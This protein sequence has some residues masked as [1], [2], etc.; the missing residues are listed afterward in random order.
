[1]GHM[2]HDQFYQ[3]ENKIGLANLMNIRKS[4][5]KLTKDF[6]FRFWKVRTKCF[7]QIIKNEMVKIAMVHFDFAI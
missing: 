6:L 2:F 4:P 5:M 7:S 1:M 3:G